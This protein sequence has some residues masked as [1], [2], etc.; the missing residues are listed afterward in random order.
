MSTLT[1][2]GAGGGGAAPDVTVA[3]F[4][5]L[6][7]TRPDG[8][9]VEVTAESGLSADTVVQ[10]DEAGGVWLL[11]S[12]AVAWSVAE[13]LI[14]AFGAPDWYDTGGITVETATGA[15]MRVTDKDRTFVF[16][17]SVA[18]DALA[19]GG[20]I[21]LWLMPA[22][23]AG[24]PEVQFW[25]VGTEI[26][27]TLV[28]Q[29][30]AITLVGTGTSTVVGAYRQLETTGA[31]GVP[32]S[33]LAAQ[34]TLST[35][36]PC[37]IRARVRGQVTSSGGGDQLAIYIQDNGTSALALQAA[38]A[39]FAFVDGSNRTIR[40]TQSLE[41]STP[42]SSL[43]ST[44]SSPTSVEVVS[45]SRVGITAFY[46]D[47]NLYHS[48]RRNADTTAGTALK[49]Q[50]ANFAGASTVATLQIQNWYVLTW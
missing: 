30:G 41:G 24:T 37:T 19:G 49:F 32:V 48:I 29:G 35:A 38:S 18:I 9:L 50:V 40:S 47:G 12:T 11:V 46:R 21:G 17:R 15:L 43:P 1:R 45:P 22:E 36:Q 10:W 7:T 13:P 14:Y 26:D 3:T 44:S 4:A 27:A 16:N 2:F 34:A 5:D 8:Y 31:T 25:G 23:Y 28:A 20:T 39:S 42:G 33:A 6:P